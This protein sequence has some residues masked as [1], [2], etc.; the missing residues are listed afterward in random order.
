MF[1]TD[2]DQ[3]RADWPLLRDSSINLYR[4][5]DLFRQAMEALGRLDYEIVHI[6]VERRGQFEA[7]LS[8]G[9]RWME[10]F[11][12][13]PWDGSLN[14]LNDG[15]R[16]PHEYGLKSDL[17]FCFEGFHRLSNTD[18]LYAEGVLDVIARQSRHHLLEG[19]RMV[20]LIQTDN[21]NYHCEGLGGVSAQ[22]NAKEW[23]TEDRG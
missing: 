12:Y 10:Q 18:P 13:R 7:D 3:Q 14:A 16:Y 17:A 4:R 5:T 20:A 8:E 22:W 9:L 11:G 1:A 6:V 19:R 21:G 15:L 2:A 23:F